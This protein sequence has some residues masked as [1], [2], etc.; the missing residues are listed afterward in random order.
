MEYWNN[1]NSKKFEF[2]ETK[3]DPHGWRHHFIVVLIYID[4]KRFG[5]LELR[6]IV[7]DGW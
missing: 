3:A 4:N 1:Q 5:P 6:N 2:F 7:L